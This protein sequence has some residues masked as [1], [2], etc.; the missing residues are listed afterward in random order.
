MIPQDAANSLSLSA[1]C[2][3]KTGEP[4]FDYE[5]LLK[6]AGISPS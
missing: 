1:F 5:R 6:Q 2:D 3:S 4:D